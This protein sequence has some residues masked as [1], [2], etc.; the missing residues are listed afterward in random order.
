MNEINIGL[1]TEVSECAVSLGHLVHIFL[2]LVSTALVVECVYDFGSELLS[3]CLATALAG[4]EDQIFHRDRL[5]AV[6]TDFSRNLE[7]RTT[8]TT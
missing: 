2:A 3:H 8:D 7:C 4:V 1:E 5:L 6:G